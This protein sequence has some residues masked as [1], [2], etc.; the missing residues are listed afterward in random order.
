MVEIEN[1]CPICGESMEY[2]DCWQCLGTGGFHD[3]DH[4][5]INVDCPE[6]KGHGLYLQC[7][8]LPHTDEQM[9]AHQARQDASS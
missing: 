3:W 9:A 1:Y 6:C 8:A 2:V 5:K 4:D 7:V